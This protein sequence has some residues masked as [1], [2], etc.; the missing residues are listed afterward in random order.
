MRSMR[1]IFLSILYIRY[2]IVFSVFGF[3]DEMKLYQT[4]CRR[5][6][7]MSEKTTRC[8]NVYSPVR[9]WLPTV[10]VKRVII[11]NEFLQVSSIVKSVMYIKRV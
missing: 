7:R 9:S 5:L 10:R 11:T 4:L 8:L 3:F 2:A 6:I 1:W